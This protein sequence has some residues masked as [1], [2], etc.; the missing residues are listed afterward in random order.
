LHRR[1]IRCI[2]R[3]QE[4]APRPRWQ[5]W[6]DAYEHFLR[7]DRALA[8]CSRAASLRGLNNHLSWQFRDRPLRWNA[9][10][11]YLQLAGE[12]AEM[13]SGGGVAA[14]AVG[15]S[16][17]S[18]VSGASRWPVLRKLG[19][20]FLKIVTALLSKPLIINGAGEGNRTL[21]SITGAS[22]PLIFNDLHIGER[23]KLRRLL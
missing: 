11:V 12:R 9:D 14:V 20:G 16:E 3:F 19:A 23:P 22:L 13:R 17:E 1:C 15:A 10:A 6:F 7:V 4:P 21:I 2:G 18:N 5:G 8:D